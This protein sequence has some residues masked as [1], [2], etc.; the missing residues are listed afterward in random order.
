LSIGF[1]GF[2]GTLLRY[3]LSGV[4]ARRYGETFPYGTLVVNSVG[5]FVIGFLFYFFYDRALASPTS[6]T[7]LFVGL[8]GGFTTFSS[9]GLQTFTLLRDGEVFLAVVNVV[10]S[11]LIGLA[12]VWVGYSLAKVIA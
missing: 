1:A 5:C 11:N 7:A 12:L 8:L 2:I 10:A 6:R 3:W 4:V 9:Y